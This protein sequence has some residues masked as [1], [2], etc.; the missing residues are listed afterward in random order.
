MQPGKRSAKF[1]KRS[2][3]PTKR[4]RT[5]PHPAAEEEDLLTPQAQAN[6]PSAS[7]L[8]TRV[9][10]PTHVLPLTTLC[11]R[12]FADNLRGL[13]QNPTAWEASRPYLKLLPDAL[14]SRV[15]A[16][17]KATSS[18]LLSHAFI[19]AYFLRGDSIILDSSLP[20]I[21][22]AT[23]SAIS[24]STSRETLREL[25][26]SGFDKETDN[27]FAS[28]V[29]KL[30]SLQVLVLRFCAKVGS[31]TVEAAAKNCPHLSVVNLNY[32]AVTPLSLVPL[33]TA[34]RD[35]EVLKLAG[36]THWN[37]TAVTKLW[38]AL[39]GDD[40]LQN[41]Q[42]R[43]LRTLNVR[44]NFL[45]DLSLTTLL[46]LCPNLT[47]VDLSFTVV[48]NPAALLEGKTLEKLS[49]TS[50][51]TSIVD[52]VA[53]VPGFTEL[54][55]LNIG[56]LGGGQ[57]TRT[58]AFSNATA[59]TLTDQGLCDLTDAL[60]NCVNLERVSLVGNTKLGMTGRRDSAV[61]YFI[62]Q[63][64]RNCKYLNFANISSLRSSDLE[65]LLSESIDEGPCPLTVLHLNNTAVDDDAAPYI[66]SCSSLRTLALAGTKFTSA[67]LF[68]II[69]ACPMLEELDLTSC[70][71]VS[72]VD[73]RR[74][75]EVWDEKWKNK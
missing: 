47:R 1:E 45:S 48:R 10:P 33:I 63:V 35:L 32:T 75:F 27:L 21:R 19:V 69:D 54:K 36:I 3:P 61:A 49:L 16:A 68:P 60:V 65:G 50:T 67:G 12:V 14:V 71:G 37:D 40:N 30:P 17:L 28:V 38:N 15:F 26:L 43:K 59:M 64:G 34:C 18:A 25:S 13:A 57:G 29:S 7:A 4:R 22:K 74:F 31:K 55:T 9:L 56:A 11:I 72:V 41:F 42:L 53:V 8:S 6:A 52:L 20:G 66:S 62:R 44:Q 46:S 70:R 24:E 51:M 2:A 5:N 58:A 73:R 39:G 23:L